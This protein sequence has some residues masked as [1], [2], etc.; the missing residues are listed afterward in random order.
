M[1]KF[2]LTALAGATIAFAAPQL[3]SAVPVAPAGLGA[4]A[5]TVTS[6]EQVHHRS[7]HHRGRHHHHRHNHHRRHHH[8][9]HWR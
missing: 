2:I 1:R 7:W 8:H 6:T 4:A 9:H 5:D 3:A